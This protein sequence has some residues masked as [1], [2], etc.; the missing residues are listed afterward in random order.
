MLPVFDIRRMYTQQH[1]VTRSRLIQDRFN[2]VFL[3]NCEELCFAC[4]PEKSEV[5]YHKVEFVKYICTNT[6]LINILA[7]QNVATLLL[8]CIK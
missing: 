4:D 3:I 6:R 5:L 1:R 7:S 2:G 8:Y